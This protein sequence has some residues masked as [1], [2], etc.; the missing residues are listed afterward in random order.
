[1][2]AGANTF[3]MATK[4]VDLKTGDGNQVAAFDLST[5]KHK[6]TIS[7]PAEQPLTPLRT[8]GGKLLMYLGA[9]K[10]KGGGI[11]SVPAMRR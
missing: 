8:E 7:S 1:M 2:A 6:W 9:A 5:G 3:Y 10:N 4:A 11:A